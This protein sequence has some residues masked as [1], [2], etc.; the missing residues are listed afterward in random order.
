MTPASVFSTVLTMSLTGSFAILAVMF[1]R[2]CLKK[3]PKIFS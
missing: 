2:L 1:F 3:A